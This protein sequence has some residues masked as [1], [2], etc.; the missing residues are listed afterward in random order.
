V[1]KSAP[2]ATAPATETATPVPTAP[3]PPPPNPAGAGHWSYWRLA[4]LT[5]A[6]VVAL[7]I[8][9]LVGLPRL[10]PGLDRR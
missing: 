10:R 9:A 8:V 6:A 5:L 3:Q 1:E 7:S 4:E 2:S